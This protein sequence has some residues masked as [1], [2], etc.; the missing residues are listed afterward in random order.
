MSVS[1]SST[2]ILWLNDFYDWQLCDVNYFSNEDFLNINGSVHLVKIDPIIARNNMYVSKEI[3]IFNNRDNDGFQLYQCDSPSELRKNIPIRFFYSIKYGKVFELQGTSSPFYDLFRFIFT[4]LNIRD[5]IFAGFDPWYSDLVGIEKYIRTFFDNVKGRIGRFEIIECYTNSDFFYKSSYSLL[6]NR[7]NNYYA[8]NLDELKNISDT[9][10][11]FH[12]FLLKKLNALDIE[13]LPFSN[14]SRLIFNENTL[15][16]DNYYLLF[17]NSLFENRVD[18]QIS[19]GNE[20][21][22]SLSKERLISYLDFHPDPDTLTE[23]ERDSF[24]TNTIL[25]PVSHEELGQ[26]G[27][28]D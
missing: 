17:K 1:S 28:A 24:L 6:L 11:S 5:D 19:S 26:I 7:I 4:N 23:S 13:K 12:N 18:F 25:F 20:G 3:Q 14:T 9:N 27:Y 16:L 2:K 21:L 15:Y 22:V 8:R 10:I